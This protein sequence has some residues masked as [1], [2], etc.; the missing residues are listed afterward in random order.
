M[1]VTARRQGGTAVRVSYRFA[2]PDEGSARPV[3]IVVR[4]RDAKGR[5]TARSLRVRGRTGSVRLTGV[6]RSMVRATAIAVSSD[7]HRASSPTVRI[8]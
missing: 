1:S 6:R 3:R 2:R 4:F 5:T 7:G 8:G